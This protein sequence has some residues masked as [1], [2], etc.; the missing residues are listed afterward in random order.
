MAKNYTKAIL[1]TGRPLTIACHIKKE[2]F[3]LGRVSCHL[4]GISG[5][6]RRVSAHLGRIGGHLGGISGHLG[7][8][9][10]S[11]SA[12]TVITCCESADSQYDKELFHL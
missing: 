6:L 5:H 4:G 11:F 7:G 8:I 9:S 12:C 2:L 3:L 1:R 10:F